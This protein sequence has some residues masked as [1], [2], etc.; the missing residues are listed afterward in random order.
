MTE[1]NG[2]ISPE[3][4]VEMDEATLDA[5]SGGSGLKLPMD[6][7]LGYTPKTPDGAGKKV[8]GDT[9]THEVGH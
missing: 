6:N 4:L 8:L 7:T 5:V 1:F 2:E 9:A 3:G